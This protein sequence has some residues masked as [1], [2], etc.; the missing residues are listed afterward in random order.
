MAIG[1]LAYTGSPACFSPISEN[2]IPYN[3]VSAFANGILFLQ[4]ISA[5][6]NSLCNKS[7]ALFMSAIL[8]PPSPCLTGSGP[9]RVSLCPPHTWNEKMELSIHSP[10]FHRSYPPLSESGLYHSIDIVLKIIYV[11]LIPEC[12][13][14]F[15]I[16]PFSSPPFSLPHW[17]RGLLQASESAWENSISQSSGVPKITPGTST[18]SFRSR[19]NRINPLSLTAFLYSFTFFLPPTRNGAYPLWNSATIILFFIFSLHS[20]LPHW[21]RGF[22]FFPM[23]NNITMQAH[24]Q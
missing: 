15:A 20:S 22:V 17:V 10:I 5:S 4:E 14:L 6:G 23:T 3:C 9:T 12:E 19:I 21:V 11:D 16:F 7:K 24:C 8:S 1:P 13:N 18:T 2:S